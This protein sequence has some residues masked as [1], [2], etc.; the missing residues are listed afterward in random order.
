MSVLNSIIFNTVPDAEQYYDTVEALKDLE[1]EYSRFTRTVWKASRQ[2]LKFDEINRLTA[3]AVEDEA[4]SASRSSS[5]SSSSRRSSGS[6]SS[7]SSKT[8]KTGSSAKTGSSSA[9]AKTSVPDI[10]KD[11]A[12]ELNLR[13][14]LFNTGNI[15]WGGIDWEQLVAAVQ[16]GLSSI[17]G[18]VLFAAVGAA[19]G[20]ISGGPLG[21]F[22]GLS[23]G[24]LFGIQADNFAFD[25]DGE[26]EPGEFENAL[27]AILPALLGGVLGLV[28]FGPAGAA[29]GLVLGAVLS[30]K[31]MNFD[32]SDLLEKV[33]GLFA[34]L[35]ETWGLHWDNWRRKLSGL[36]DGLREWWSGLVLDRFTFRLPHITVDW[37]E[38][39][40]NSVLSRV[41]GIPAIPHL[42]VEWYARGGIVDGA[43]LIGAGEEGKE[44]VV[45]LERHTEW[46]RLVAAELAAELERLSPAPSALLRTLPAS[47]TPVPYAALVRPASEAPDLSGLADTLARAISELGDRAAPDPEIRLYLD[48]RQL[49]DAVTRY[50]RRS[51]RASGI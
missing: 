31:V 38:L 37:E 48:G 41:L 10:S 51:S 16:A 6:S 49:S 50:Q 11:F 19:V 36:W 43:T 24:L 35:K 47:V 29:I 45:P 21:L 14:L 15:D 44:A 28:A 4:E 46:I 26:L 42:G 25:W 8:T 32:Y 18:G 40:A 30:F 33:R 20:G 3:A 39:S 23:A 27:R 12:M 7:S 17:S 34:D 1:R 22:I 9:A 5:G 13:D 2:L